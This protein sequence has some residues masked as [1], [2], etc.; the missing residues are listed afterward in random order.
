[1]IQDQVFHVYK[2]NTD[3]TEVIAHNLSVDQLEEK[4]IDKSVDLA[5][6]EVQPCY[7]EYSEGDASF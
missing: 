3:R 5:Q 4:L 7:T 2:K 1:M 6:H